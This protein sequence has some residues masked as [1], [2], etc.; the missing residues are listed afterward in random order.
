MSSSALIT[1]TRHLGYPEEDQ[2]EQ[3]VSAAKAVLDRVQVTLN[4][5]KQAF[6]YLYRAEKAL[7]EC[8]AKLKDALQCAA[9]CQLRFY[10]SYWRKS[11]NFLFTAMFASGR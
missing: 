8:K 5:E 4:A 1:L 6:E 7:R 10:V 3:Q 2:L 11:S 9:T